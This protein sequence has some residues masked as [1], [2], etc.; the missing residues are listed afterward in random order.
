MTLKS[1]PMVARKSQNP[2]HLERP[3]LEHCP[4]MKVTTDNNFLVSIHGSK[5]YTRWTPIQF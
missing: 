5:D 3:I 4:Q 2:D 1:T